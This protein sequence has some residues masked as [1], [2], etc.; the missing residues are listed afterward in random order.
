[1]GYEVK[2]IVAGA[3]SSYSESPKW[4]NVIAQIDMCKPGYESNLYRLCKNRVGT[5]V[6]FYA[7]DGNTEITEDHYGEPLVAIPI[8][9]V[10][11][12][13]ETDRANDP[14]WRFDLA[15]Q[16]LAVIAK[17]YPTAVCALYGY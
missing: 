4:L 12:A 9:E 6:F 3:L 16:T 13:V 1:M 5:P 11:Q 15:C 2:I 17:N 7:E 8:H 10:L 14:Y